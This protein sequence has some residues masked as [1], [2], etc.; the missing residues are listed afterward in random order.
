MSNKVTLLPDYVGTVQ[1]PS[2]QFYEKST[3]LFDT[4]KTYLGELSTNIEFEK[5][6]SAQNIAQST[7]SV[8]KALNDNDF[9]KVVNEV[10]FTFDEGFRLYFIEK[11]QTLNESLKDYISE[12]IGKDNTYFINYSDDIGNIA[13]QTSVVD[14]STSPYWDTYDQEFNFPNALPASLF[15]KVS[16]SERSTSE[17]L[18]IYTDAVLKTNLSG[19]VDY[20]SKD[21][22]KTSHGKNLVDDNLY[23]DR[24]FLL[25]DPVKSKIRSI[26]NEMADFIQFFKGVN[27]KDKDPERNALDIVYTSGIE[28]V[29]VE[30]D[31]L[32]NSV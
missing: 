26:L 5:S 2:V 11:Y 12:V 16:K 3:S 19:L 6:K 13:N 10:E 31:L 14:N 22:A 21:I 18:S 4:F 29:Q 28:G 20:T 17:K 30:I 25:K 27:F 7:A 15:N 1:Q 9:K 24:L 32:K 8:F 23:V